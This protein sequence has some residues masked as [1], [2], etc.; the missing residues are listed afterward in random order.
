M[1]PTAQAQQ[2]MQAYMINQERN[3]QIAHAKSAN[4]PVARSTTPSNG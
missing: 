4:P 1:N 2:E 3:W